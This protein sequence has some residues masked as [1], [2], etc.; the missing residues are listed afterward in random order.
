MNTPLTK[1]EE[2]MKVAVMR[3][4]TFAYDVRKVLIPI[5]LEIGVCVLF[6]VATAS[7]VSVPHIATNL[8]HL[9]NITEWVTYMWGAFMQTKIIVQILSLL[10]LVSL[11]VLAV[12]SLRKIALVARVKL[13]T[14]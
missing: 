4:V 11:T 7:L 6:L 10:V 13:V 3:R 1:K 5:A 9:S 2:L 8:Y 14:A 12:D